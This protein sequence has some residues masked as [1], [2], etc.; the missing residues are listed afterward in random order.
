[1]DTL[2]TVELVL[3]LTERILNIDDLDQIYIGDIKALK[4]LLEQEI[5]F[6]DKLESLA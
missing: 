1:M 3:G 6:R 2:A 4:S 5:L